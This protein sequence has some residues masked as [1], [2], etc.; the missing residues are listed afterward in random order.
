YVYG[1]VRSRAIPP[2]ATGIDAVPLR[3]VA[4]GDVAAVVHD[5]DGEPYGGSDDEVRR[6]ALEHNAVVERLW[7][8][9]RAILPMSFDVIVAPSASESA[10]RRLTRWLEEVAELAKARLAATAGRVE[11]RVDIG[12]DPARAAAHD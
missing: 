8:E 7:H 6:R 10:E 12:L 11:L 5:H 2:D 4:V 9:D 1:L 3:A